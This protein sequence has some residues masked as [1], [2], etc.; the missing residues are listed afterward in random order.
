VAAGVA[1]AL[2]TDGNRAAAE[3]TPGAI[4]T[5]CPPSVAV[6]RVTGA[7]D[8]FMAAHIAAQARGA[9]GKAALETALAAAA[10]HVAAE[11]PT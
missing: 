3:G 2:V 8:S 4:V 7:G 9:S 6:A 10:A 5:A 1:Q 11:H